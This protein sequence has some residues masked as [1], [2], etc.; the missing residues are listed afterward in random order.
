MEPVLMA[1]VVGRIESARPYTFSG[2]SAASGTTLRLDSQPHASWMRE[3]A[4][5]VWEPVWAFAVPPTPD[6]TLGEGPDRCQ[7]E[8]SRKLGVAT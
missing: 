6:Q 5:M 4:M 8:P 2:S 7:I 3:V 1:Q